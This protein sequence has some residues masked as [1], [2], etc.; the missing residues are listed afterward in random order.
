MALEDAE[1]NYVRL[2]WADPHRLSKFSQ[3]Q[4]QDMEVQRMLRVLSN[5]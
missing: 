5:D 2:L 1:Q 3:L 4:T